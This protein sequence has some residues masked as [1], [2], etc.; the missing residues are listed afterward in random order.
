MD[1]VI[2]TV[3]SLWIDSLF[4]QI[5]HKSTIHY[6]S[7]LLYLFCEVIMNQKN[8]HRLTIYFKNSRWIHCIFREYFESSICLANLECINYLNYYISV[9]FSHISHK[10]EWK[11]FCLTFDDSCEYFKLLRDDDVKDGLIEFQYNNLFLLSLEYSETSRILGKNIRPSS[12][13]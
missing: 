7:R 9:I 11:N 6:A 10:M 8:Y 12:K 5:H 13:Y 3:K 2:S 1:F 4:S